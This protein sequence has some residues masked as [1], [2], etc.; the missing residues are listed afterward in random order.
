MLRKPRLYHSCSAEEDEDLYCTLHY[1]DKY[2]LLSF[3]TRYFITFYHILPYF[4]ILQFYILIW[5]TGLYSKSS[6]IIYILISCCLLYHFWNT[7]YFIPAFYLLFVRKGLSPLLFLCI[8]ALPDDGSSG[9]PK[10]A[11]VLN[12]PIT[13]DTYS[14]VCQ[15]IK[16]KIQDMLPKIKSTIIKICTTSRR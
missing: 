16:I 10:H 3:P 1:I 9:Q 4:T 5:N 12:K 13:T 11:V 15:I 14:W 2:R 7:N 8:H 6:N